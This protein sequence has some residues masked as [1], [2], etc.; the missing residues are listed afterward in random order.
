MSY[1]NYVLTQQLLQC[2]MYQAE[3]MKIYH[4]LLCTILHTIRREKAKQ[5]KNYNAVD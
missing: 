2:V 1:E 3:A 4:P 5:R